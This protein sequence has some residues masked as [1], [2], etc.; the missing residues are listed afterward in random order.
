M[1]AYSKLVDTKA[2]TPVFNAGRFNPL[3][4]K[5]IN[6]VICHL[7]QQ[8]GFNQGNYA[9]HSFRIDATTTAAAAAGLPAWMIKA[10]G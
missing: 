6:T 7:L 4:Q 10:L 9:S 5:K 3:T 2:H 1:T 8:G